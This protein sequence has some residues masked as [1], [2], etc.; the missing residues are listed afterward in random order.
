MPLTCLNSQGK[1]K[2]ILAYSRYTEQEISIIISNFEE[3]EQAVWVDFSSLK[4]K[5]KQNIKSET[6][7]LMIKFWESGKHQYHL[8]NEFLN[9]PSKFTVDGYDS[10][11]F[12]ISIVGSIESNPEFYGE[13][14]NNF[15]ET[16]NLIQTANHMEASHIYSNYIKHLVECYNAHKDPDYSLKIKNQSDSLIDFHKF[17]SKDPKVLQ[18]I[19]S[20][21]EKNLLGPVVFVTCELAPWFKI[22]GLAVMVDELARGLANLNQDTYVIVPYYHNKKGT[23]DPI[24][25]DPQGKYGIKYLFNISVN[26]GE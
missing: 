26:L 7:I 3:Y 20:I 15:L 5:L 2:T 14:R 9:C 18:I 16:L 12:Q 1:V 6:T 21:V 19:E 22:G 17:V 8:I 11:L 23:N 10:L 13:A 24:D 25:L 4:E